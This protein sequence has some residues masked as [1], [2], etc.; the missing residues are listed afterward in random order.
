MK[1]EMKY[2]VIWFL[3]IPFMVGCTVKN[4]DKAKENGAPEITEI[5]S[6]DNSIKTRIITEEVFLRAM[7]DFKANRISGDSVRK[8]LRDSISTTFLKGWIQENQNDTTGAIQSVVGY[9]YANGKGCEKDWKKSFH[10]FQQGAE[11]G[12][13]F[14]MNGLGIQYNL[15]IGVEKNPSKAVEWYAKAAEQGDAV[16]QRNLATCYYRGEGVEKNLSKAVEW[17]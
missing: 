17:Y 15:G 11:K 3:L 9:L 13:P 12:I 7:Q 8:I 14:A 16:A 6:N 5:E 1:I 10:L 4:D 2:I